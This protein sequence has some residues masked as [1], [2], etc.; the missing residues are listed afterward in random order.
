MKSPSG[1]GPR[2]KYPAVADSD[3]ELFT[4]EEWAKSIL[5][6]KKFWRTIRLPLQRQ[7]K[8]RVA[9]I[10]V[11]ER[12]H[13]DTRRG[14][15]PERW[16]LCEQYSD[17]TLKYYISNF[18]ESASIRKIIHLAHAR[19]K[20]EQGYQ[21]LK[22]ELGLDHYEGRSW[23]GLHHHISLCFMAFDFLVSLQNEDF[24]KKKQS[25]HPE[26]NFIARSAA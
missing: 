12:L 23:L 21:Q 17:G 6:K 25:E 7:K 13:A 8:V 9:A 19:Y 22:E 16:L 4:A 11:R 5:K 15:G 14:V 26:A 18:P 2:R 10:R 1:R 20:V 24:K 3:T